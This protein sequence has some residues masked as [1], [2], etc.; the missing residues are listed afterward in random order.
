MIL[1]HTTLGGAPPGAYGK[2]SLEADWGQLQWEDG[3]SAGRVWLVEAADTSPERALRVRYPRG[4]VGPRAGGAQ[5]CLRLP[6]AHDELFASYRLRFAPGFGFVRGGKLP[7]LAGGA[8]NT[9][10]SRPNGRDG[11]SARM[12]WREDGKVVQYVYHPDQAGIWGDDLAWDVG[13][14]RHFQPGQWHHVQHHVSLN[15]P[16]HHDGRVR[17][18]FDGELALDASGLRFRDDP[19]LRLDQFYFSTF[20]GGNDPSWAPER[21]ETIEFADFTIA[22]TLA[23]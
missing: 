19:A 12:M 18:W 14:P 22:T 6:S 9:G 1:F 5:W 21:D 3:V 15:Q 23:P 2:Q 17:G 20:F 4:A 11:F 8:A 10:G 13:A 7:G 16:G